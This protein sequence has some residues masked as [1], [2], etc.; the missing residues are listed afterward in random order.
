MR[1]KTKQIRYKENR[2]TSI[3]GSIVISFAERYSIMALQILAT[4]ILSRLLTPSEI[5]IYAVGMAVVSFAHILRDFGITN[6]LISAKNIDDQVVRNALGATILIAWLIGLTLWLASPA[7]G[8]L[9]GESG[10][11]D[12]LATLAI[13]FI[14]LPFGS[15]IF[16]IMRR[17]LDFP[18]ILRINLG[19]A[20]VQNTTA[21]LLAWQGFGFMSLAWSA[22]AGT[23][24]TT[25]LAIIHRNEK[26]HLVPMF[27][28]MRPVISFGTKETLT[29]FFEELRLSAPSLVLGQTTTMHQVGLFNRGQGLVEM[30]RTAITSA[31][32]PVVLPALAE[33]YRSN[34]PLKNDILLAMKLLSAALWP[35]FT[36]VAYTSEQ[37]IL[38]LF[39][40]Q[41]IAAAQPA[42]YLALIAIPSI[43][44]FIVSPLLVVHGRMNR[45][46][47][48]SMI[49]GAA[50]CIGIF[51]GSTHSLEAAAIGVVAASFITIPLYH[52][53]LSAKLH[54]SILEVARCISVP[55][56]AS[57]AGLSAIMTF[58][59]FFAEETLGI[60]LYMLLNGF[61]FFSLCLYFFALYKHPAYFEIRRAGKKIM[62]FGFK[63]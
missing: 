9:Y 3:R 38:F 58:N 4:I 27:A 1:P 45:R 60:T 16:A 28:R 57:I 6:Y 62:K 18:G 51:L 56:F 36:F 31:V 39:G 52:S 46:L 55:T 20:A 12:V 7:I 32:G 24:T 43:Y 50:T 30:F 25:I 26:K 54:I 29:R 22:L 61:I 2:K 41:W 33:K 14:L 8:T 48:I 34:Q 23:F 53:Y 10:T 49:Y 15:T 37:I 17:E 63:A 35:M 11:T 59:Y 13:S 5:G 40:E 47:A 19:S 21:V 44:G 42:K